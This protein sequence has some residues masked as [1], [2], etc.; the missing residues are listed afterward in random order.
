MAWTRQD[1]EAL[2]LAKAYIEGGGAG[3]DQSNFT[4]D[5][6]NVL[7]RALFALSESDRM[8]VHSAIESPRP[9]L[10]DAAITLLE[11]RLRRGGMGQGVA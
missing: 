10:T 1:P 3:F 6:L 4:E 5:Q 2:R 9:T 11:M 8:M 7:A